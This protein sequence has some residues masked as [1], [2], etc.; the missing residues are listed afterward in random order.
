MSLIYRKLYRLTG[1]AFPLIYYFTDKKLALC[2][3]AVIIILIV[4]AEIL[5]FR[6]P[7][8]NR[9]I[10]RY[11]GLILKE[12]EKRKISGTTLFLI[13]SLLTI[14]LFQ[15][16]IAITAL[17]FAVFG[18]AIAAISGTWFGRARIK[19]KSLEGSLACFILCFLIGAV[20]VN[21]NLGINIK[22]VFFGAL[23]AT[24]MEILP[25]GIDDNLTMPIFAGL[26]MELARFLWYSKV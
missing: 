7:A 17:T 12:K 1:L 23:A 9:G 4:A 18:D 19:G 22:L 10:F 16:A 8:I 3:L 13:A 15:K 20:L 6:H 24:I 14:F 26:I 5:R 11:F 21:I 2:V 25:I